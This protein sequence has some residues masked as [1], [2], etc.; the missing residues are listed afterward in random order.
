[1]WKELINQFLNKL[2]REYEQTNYLVSLIKTNDQ[3]LIDDTYNGAIISMCIKYESLTV[4]LYSDLFKEKNVIY[5]RPWYYTRKI[6]NKLHVNLGSEY[7]VAR[8]LWTYY[9]ALK[10]INIRTKEK[11]HHLADHYQLSDTKSAHEFTYK[12]LINL[13]NSFKIN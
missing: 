8:D 10:H 3:D 1:M 9:D 13:I 6:V 12:T 2:N 5:N 7:Y 4:D 11:L